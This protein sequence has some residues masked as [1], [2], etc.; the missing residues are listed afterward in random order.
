MTHPERFGPVGMAQPYTDAG[1]R[2]VLKRAVNTLQLLQTMLRQ[3]RD[4][5]YKSND[6]PRLLWAIQ[7][8]A[9]VEAQLHRIFRA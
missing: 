5:A 1:V 4:Q 9:A 7:R 3:M 6:T 2:D 8:M